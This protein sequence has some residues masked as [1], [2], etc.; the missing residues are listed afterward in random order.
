MGYH[1][2]PLERLS[3]KRALKSKASGL[4]IFGAL[5]GKSPQG[6]PSAQNFRLI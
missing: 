4:A 2:K 5:E 3:F 6:F 1:L